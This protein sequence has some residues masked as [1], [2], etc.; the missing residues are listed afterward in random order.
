MSSEKLSWFDSLDKVEGLGAARCEFLRENDF[1]TVGDLLLRAPLRFV[2]RRDSPPFNELHTMHGAEVTAVGTVESMGEKG[3]FRKRRLMAIISD[4]SGGNLTGIWFSNYG[5][6][7]RTLKPGMRVAFSGK[8]GFFDGPQIAH[9][10]ITYLEEQDDARLEIG[11]IPVYPSGDQ[12]VKHG[13]NRRYFS[14]LIGEIIE[15]WDG[16]GPYPP[17]EIQTGLSLLSLRDAIKGLHHP[18]TVEEYDQAVKSIKFTELFLHQMLM[19]AL[20]RRRRLRDGI[21]LQAAEKYD[22]FLQALP[23]KLSDGQEQVIS[24][25]AADLREGFPMHRLVQGEVGAGKTVL[26]F[27]SAAIA[28]DSGFQTAIMAPTELLARQHYQNAID[29]LEKAG[30]RVA[31]VVAGRNREQLREALYA[32][33]VGSADVII[34]TQALFQERVTLKRL[35][36]V[37]IDEQQRFGVAQRSRLIGKGSHPHVLLMTAT[38]IPRTLALAHYGDID[39]SLLPTRPGVE[40]HIKTRVVHD[41]SRGKVFGWLRDRLKEGERGYL[42]FPVIDE[43]VA[44]LEAAEARFKPYQTVDFRGVPVGLMHGRQ[45]VD[46]RIRTMEAF[47]AG[48]IRLLMATAVVE[49]G[50]DVQEA[51]LM[52]VENSERFGLAQLHQLR[53]RIGRTG[54]KAVCVFLTSEPSDHPGFERLKRLETSD[55]GFT[56]AEEDLS[57]RGAGEPLGARQSGMTRFRIADPIAD[58]EL[59]KTAHTTAMWLMDKDSKLENYPELRDQIKRDYRSGP[60]TYLAG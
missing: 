32:T 53:G 28:A 25:I 20:R 49:V 46:E 18:E 8:L 51:N 57:L 58:K 31:L 7:K 59:L 35:G 23:F 52:V 16:T 12:W 37:V 33:A 45:P 47:R 36:L 42:I 24:E 38:P 17:K 14:R 54:A 3:G 48:K 21:V 9:P 2:D 50:V 10:K 19:V 1:A 6:I 26:A 30:M 43:G 34:G 15:A 56:L 60:R 29:W 11:L 41:S 55:D 22:K 27:A 4:G 40:R 13:F 39:H 5:Y 44:G